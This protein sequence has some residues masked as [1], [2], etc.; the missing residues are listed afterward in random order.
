MIETEIRNRIKLLKMRRDKANTMDA[1][2]LQ[3]IAEEF[4][5]SAN[6]EGVVL[7]GHG[8]FFSA[9]LNLVDLYHGT[10]EDV[11]S[12]FTALATALNSVMTFPG[13]VIAVVNGHAVAGGCL[14]ALCCD[15][16]MGVAGN[17]K[18]GI[19]ELAIG[20]DLPPLGLAV[21]RRSVA[22][23]QLF[24]I[25]S[26]GK[27]YTPEE[28][29]SVGLLN[30]LADAGSALELALSKAEAMAASLAPFQRLK[31]RMLRPEA[32]LLAKESGSVVEFVDQ[33]FAPETQAKIKESVA[34][35]K[36]S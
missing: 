12:V 3:R 5:Q 6:F 28:G 10:R 17:Y 30:E 33:W 18:M 11:K 31:E 29:V 2:F 22:T 21:V 14:L 25:A 9:G 24:D 8:R 27:F 36:G 23:N 35:L 19:N 20:L 7:T 34:R 15:Y 26:L 13:P 1:P 16:R 4:E 32:K